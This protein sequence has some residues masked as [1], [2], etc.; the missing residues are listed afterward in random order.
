MYPMPT[1][2]SNETDVVHLA[3]RQDCKFGAG[4]KS[5][6][7]RIDL[8]VPDGY[9]AWA[10]DFALLNDDLIAQLTSSAPPEK[11]NAL[12]A[13]GWGVLP[14][15]YWCHRRIGKNCLW[16]YPWACGWSVECYFSTKRVAGVL[17]ID[18]MPIL[19]STPSSAIHIAEASYPA[20]NPFLRWLPR[21]TG[22]C[23]RPNPKYRT[24]L[25]SS[26][27]APRG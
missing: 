18:Y 24:P 8:D 17:T 6:I 26:V 27:G 25:Q 15:V 2:V 16:I 12:R 4:I 3:F 19:C 13:R 14:Y 22:F 10:D 5:I 1:T 7:K 20:P 11:P 9:Y 21:D 23:C